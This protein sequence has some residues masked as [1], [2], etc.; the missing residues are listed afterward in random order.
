M[1]S[2][3]EDPLFI[4]SIEKGFTIIEL[5]ERVENDLSLSEI[6]KATGY[7]ISGT[8]RLLFTLEKL[9]YL[10]KNQQTKRYTPG[11]KSL[12][13]GFEYN[14]LGRIKRASL[15]VI[16]ALAT[17]GQGDI[18]LMA[19]NKSNLINV[20]HIPGKN[21]CVK[22]TAPGHPCSLIYSAGG[23]SVLS[24]LPS[25]QAVGLVFSSQ[26][27]TYTNK[28]ITDPKLILNEIETAYSKGFSIIDGETDLGTI[29]IGAAILA[30]DGLP[31]AA[32]EMSA[33]RQ[34]WKWMKQREQFGAKL[35]QAAKQ[36]AENLS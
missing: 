1:A 22:V 29:S 7:G 9:G 24:H 14:R 6:A 5:F 26:K 13:I 34:K 15:K 21:I 12:T 33:P 36:I 25:M 28:T 17:L 3:F 35:E 2:K 30:K 32:L 10:E 23:R 31:I 4:K 18:F 16:E 27:S 11:I 19:F 8:Q 20:M